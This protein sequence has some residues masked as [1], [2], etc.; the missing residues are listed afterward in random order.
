MESWI[1]MLV[2]QMILVDEPAIASASEVLGSALEK[3]CA[4]DSGAPFATGFPFS[5]TNSRCRLPGCDPKM[6]EC[7]SPRR[8]LFNAE[9]P[10]LD[11]RDEG[12]KRAL[13]LDGASE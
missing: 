1:E 4:S 6:S 7:I 2:P 8:E 9:V 3:V 13:L 5:S 11:A 10:D 12:R